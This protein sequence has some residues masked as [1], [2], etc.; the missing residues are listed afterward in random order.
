MTALPLIFTAGSACGIN[1]Y[2]VVALLGILGRAGV[3][4]VVPAGL[5]RTDVLVAAVVMF[6]LEAVLDKIPYLDSF[7]DVVHTVVRPVC[8]ALVGAALAGQST[9]LSTAVAAAV[10]GGSALGAHV[11]KAG[12]RMAINTSPEPFSNIVVSTAE[13]L[14]VGGVVALAVFHPVLAAVIAGALLVTGLLVVY[15]CASRIRRY[16]RRRRERR[17]LRTAAG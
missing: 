16:L 9:S 2:A 1:A 10:G 7:W 17:A 11:V 15:L 13:D 12:T 3:T 5:Q 4:D 14:G 8:G 6:L